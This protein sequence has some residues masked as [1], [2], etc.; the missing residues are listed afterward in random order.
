MRNQEVEKLLARGEQRSKCAVPY[1]MV[2][3]HQGSCLEAATVILDCTGKEISNKEGEALM[4][5]C[6]G[7][8]SPCALLTSHTQERQIQI[9][10]I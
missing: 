1:R 3:R 8:G 7:C 4:L 2:V 10:K 5:H 6:K 9:E